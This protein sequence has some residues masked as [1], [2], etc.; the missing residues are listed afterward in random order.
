MK[1]WLKKH[2]FQIHTIAF[3]M[4]ILPAIPMFHAAKSGNDPFILVLIGLVVLGNILVL[5]VP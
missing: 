4:M 3:L 5:F 1:T 2:S